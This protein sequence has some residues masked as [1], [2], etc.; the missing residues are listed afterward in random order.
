MNLTFNTNF[1]YVITHISI[2]FF[3]SF[4]L[5]YM[6][7][8]LCMYTAFVFMCRLEATYEACSETIETH[9]F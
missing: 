6:Y 5:Y 4:S 9:A 2:Y 8:Y 3:I 1:K 7:D